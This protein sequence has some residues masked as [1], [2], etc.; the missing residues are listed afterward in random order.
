MS[1]TQFCHDCRNVISPSASKCPHCGRP[2]IFPNVN[3]AIYEQSALETRY[4]KEIEDAK[5]SGLIANVE[6]F[7]RAAN[8]S[9]AVIS[10]SL[11]ELQRVAGSDNQLYATYYELE[12]IRMPSGE[13]WDSR[14][15]VAD[16]IFFTNYQREIRFAALSLDSVGLSNY[17]DC[18]WVLRE[19]MITHRTSVFEMNTTIFVRDNKITGADELP[20][21]YRAIWDDRAKLCVTKLAKKINSKTKPNEYQYLLLYQGATSADD[22]FV[23]VHIFGPMTI[24][25]IEEVIFKPLPSGLDKR[26]KRVKI[27]QIAGIKEKLAKYGVT[28]N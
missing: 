5:S 21:G 24:R 15:Q 23:E 12:A 3:I 19:E 16:F 2:G 11:D 13:D 9:S 6:D 18:S 26:T 20:K 22:D 4:K 28:V 27:A 1:F 8:K 14:R 25:T 10:R 7:E 17:G